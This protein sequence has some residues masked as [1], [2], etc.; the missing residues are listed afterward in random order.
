MTYD[1]TTRISR[2]DKGSAK[3]EY[4]YQCCDKVEDNI[5]PLSVAD[6]EFKTPPCI[7]EGLKDFL[8][9]AVLGYTV[10]YKSYLEIVKKWF[11]KRHDFKIESQWIVQSPGVVNAFTAALRSLCKEG[12]GVI[13]FKPI[14]PPMVGAIESNNFKEVNIPLLNREERYEIDFDA[15]EKEASNPNNKVLLFCSPHNPVGRVWTKEELLKI[16]KICLENNITIISDEIWMDLIRPGKKH[17]ILA[18]LSPEIRDITI[19]CTAPSKS[20]NIAGLYN[21]NTI[22]SNEELRKNLKEELVKM[23]STSINILGYKACEIAYTD[24]EDWLVEL[25]KVLDENFKLC[26]D[27]FKKLNLPFANPEGT[28]ILWVNF[29]PLGLDQEELHKFLYEKARIFTSPGSNFGEEGNGYERF[30]IALP[31]EVLKEHL[32]RLSDEIKKL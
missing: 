2:K 22:V 12:D 5:V 13:V 8:D 11:L 30:N 27:F 1:F 10:P 17:H 7:V 23:R 4:M 3:W 20:F 31:T 25:L 15:F 28:Y 14:Y 21:S 26:Q 19:T 29:K 9:N 24:G 18:N 6:M 32:Q 16:G